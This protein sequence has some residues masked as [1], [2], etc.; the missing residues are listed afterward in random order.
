MPI[1]EILNVYMT[2]SSYAGHG[3]YAEKTVFALK[4]LWFQKAEKKKF[5]CSHF[6]ERSKKGEI[7]SLKMP[8]KPMI[9]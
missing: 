7:F 9:K 5:C 2:W 4:H 1:P 6:T 8:R 3:I